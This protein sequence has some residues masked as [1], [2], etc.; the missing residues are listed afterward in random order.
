MTDFTQTARELLESADRAFDAGDVREGSRLMWEAARTGIAA[1]AEKLGWPCGTREELK[2]V[3]F[4]L[5]KI[6]ESGNHPGEYAKN[7]ARFGVAEIFLE[8]AQTEEWEYPEFK[9]SEPEFRTG[10]KSV[11]GFVASLLNEAAPQH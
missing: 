10:R 7:F 4:W 8:H 3:I 5:D 11:K 1:V 2:A 9:W 6:D